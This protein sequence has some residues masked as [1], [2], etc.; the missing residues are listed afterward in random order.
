MKLVQ[1]SL[2][3]ITAGKRADRLQRYIAFRCGY[4]ILTKE[5]VGRTMASVEREPNNGGFGAKPQ[6][7]SKGRDPSGGRGKVP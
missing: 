3:L 6:S 7:G 1:W 5:V 2:S 4:R